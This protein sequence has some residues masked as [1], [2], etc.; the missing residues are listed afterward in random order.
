MKE[1]SS[2]YD[3]SAAGWW[4]GSVRWR[5]QLKKLVPARFAY[6]DDVVAD[7]SGQTVLDLGCGGGFM[8]EVLARRDAQVIGVDPSAPTIAAARD[9]ADSTRLSI[10]YRQGVGEALP[11]ESASVDVVVCVDVLEHVEDLDQVVREVR[12]VLKP[13]GLFLFDTINRTL[14]SAFVMVT[15]AERIL[16]LLPTGTHDPSNF[17]R[18]AELTRLLEG[19]GFNTSQFVGFGPRSLDRQ[20]DFGF[21][22][23]PTTSIMYMGWARAPR[24]LDTGLART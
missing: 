6:F 19:V 20:L 21:G 4:D 2:I 22:R 5:R 23:L 12:R 18:P 13:E 8:A 11:I 10:D 1:D 16:R 7:W 15:L 24:N 14:L 17:I 3:S 9:H